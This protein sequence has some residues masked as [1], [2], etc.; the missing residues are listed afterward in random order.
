MKSPQNIHKILPG[1]SEL[2]KLTKGDSSIKI[3]VLDGPVDL[4]HHAIKDADIVSLDTSLKRSIRSIHGTF[5]SS[6]IFGN[7]N[8][9][10]LGVAPNCSGLVKSIYHENE[11][12]KLRS[13]SQSD[14]AQGI[15]SALAHGADIIN[16]SGGEKV[17]EGDKIISSL[18]KALDECEKRGVLVIAATGNDGD[19][20]IHVPAS[21]PTVLAVGS[22]NNQGNPS[23]FSNWSTKETT[24]GIV[25]PGEEIVGASPIGKT[26]MAV[27]NGTSFST[28]LVS[29]VAGL[30]ASIQKA[31]GAEK[32]MI[33]IRKILLNSIT[34]CVSTEKINCDRIM[35]GRLNIANAL[36]NVLKNSAATVTAIKASDVETSTISAIDTSSK[37]N[38]NQSHNF[39]TLNITDMENETQAIPTST[40]NTAVETP[41]AQVSVQEVTPSASVPIVETAVTPSETT[42]S[43]C[44]CTNNVTPSQVPVSYSPSVNQGGYPTFRNSQLVNAIGQISY[45]FGSQNNL[46]T[47]TALMRVWYQNLKP[48]IEGF[49]VKSKLTDSPHDP[50]SMAAFLIYKANNDAP[51]LLMA[52]QLIWTLNMNATPVYSISP[53]LAAFDNLIYL[54]LAEFLGESVGMNASAYQKYTNY[55]SGM[56]VQNIPKPIFTDPKN[57]LMRM[58][59]PGYVSGKSKLL[60]SSFIES[61]T[62]VAFGLKN[63]TVSELIKSIGIKKGSDKDTLLCSILARLYVTALNR[64]QSPDDRALNYSL[65]QIIELA[66]K[67]KEIIESQQQFSCYKVVPSKIA[68]QNALVREIQLTFFNPNNT[69]IASTTYAFQIDVSG[70]VPVMIGDVESW[71]APVMVTNVPC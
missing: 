27:A 52:S 29:G 21:Y 16:I 38:V 45:D 4:K 43:S 23:N 41:T 12:G 65:H 70:I 6:L 71:R 30:F 1:I 67:L 66:D 61:V 17:N 10:I 33:I 46:D 20:R 39:L 48:D 34:P 19:K 32:D 62:P 68:R 59:L 14:I 60:N 24:Q 64:G 22:I 18:A 26:Q 35:T 15:L 42:S 3:T 2:W 53:R 56:P 58:I 31:Q 9:N 13:G 11:N 37:N 57:D 55:R 51:N 47:F 7:H 25:A 69:N 49:V 63:W 54:I 44:G 8:S 36:N 50:R 28:A 40:T 5:I